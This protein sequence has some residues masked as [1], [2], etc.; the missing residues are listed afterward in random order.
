MITGLH[1]SAYRATGGLIGGFAGTPIGLLT[2]RGRRS[3][4]E[5]VTPLNFLPDGDRFVIVASNGGS[6]T[7]PDWYRNLEADPTAT[8]QVGPQVRRVRAETAVGSERDRLW[9]QLTFWSPMYALYSTLT[10]R[11]IPVVVLHPSDS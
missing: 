11:E 8:F 10:T 7:H 9:Q 5:R 3:G 4:Q 6:A 1:A 2:T